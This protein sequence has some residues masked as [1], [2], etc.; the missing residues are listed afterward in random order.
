MS[1]HR[2][3]KNRTPRCRCSTAPS[4]N[5]RSSRNRRSIRPHRRHRRAPQGRASIHDCLVLRCPALAT[6]F[7][8]PRPSATVAALFDGRLRYDLNLDFKHERQGRTRLSRPFGVCAIYFTRDLGL[9]SPIAL[10]IKHLAASATS[11]S[12]RGHRRYPD[13]VPFR[14]H[15]PNP[16]RAGVLEATSC[17][18]KDAPAHAVAKTQ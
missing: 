1:H 16:V 7:S 9:I 12:P 8:R 15:I 10:P 2:T 18:T 3:R 13:P 5:P 17:N 6:C 14:R 4:S 11:R